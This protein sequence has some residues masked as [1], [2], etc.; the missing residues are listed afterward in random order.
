MIN[1]NAAGRFDLGAVDCSRYI[2]ITPVQVQSLYT[3]IILAQ[4]GFCRRMAVPSAVAKMR[5]H[6]I[7][8]SPIGT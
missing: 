5:W 1:S 6:V 3:F 2:R 7:L 4:S 8:S